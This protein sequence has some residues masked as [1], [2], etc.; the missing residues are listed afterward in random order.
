MKTLPLGVGIHNL[1][2]PIDRFKRFRGGGMGHGSPDGPGVGL[3]GGSPGHG[4]PD[5]PGVGLGSNTGGAPTGGGPQ[6]AA[7]ADAASRAARAGV[8]QSALSQAAAQ[9]AADRAKAQTTASAP[10]AP[11]TA[12]SADPDFGLALKGRMERAA[13]GF[14]DPMGLFGTIAK[15]AELGE[16]LPETIQ[17]KGFPVTAIQALN[18]L[19]SNYNKN[20][21]DIKSVLNN[22]FL[23]DRQKAVLMEGIRQRGF[24][25][26]YAR[27]GK[28]ADDDNVDQGW[29]PSLFD[30]SGNF[31]Q[32]AFDTFSADLRDPSHPSFKGDLSLDSLTGVFGQ[33]DPKAIKDSLQKGLGSFFGSFSSPFTGDRSPRDPSGGR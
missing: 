19:I 7:E 6:S 21:N 13:H 14:P 28:V 26:A 22:A 4:S 27:H 12:F 15:A 20:K 10:T 24:A 30:S 5:G 17:R 1:G 29:T 2:F 33:V 23:N 9:F 31:K 3:G 11:S 32:A 18:R 25:P 16:S 8:A